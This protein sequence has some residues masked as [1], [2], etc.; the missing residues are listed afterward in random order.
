M[1]IQKIYKSGE[2]NF[3]NKQLRRANLQNADLQNINLQGSD[4]SYADLRGANLRGANL[5]HCYFN[6]ANLTGADLTGA[7]LTGSYFIKAYMG[8]VNCYKAIL[9]D[10]YFTGTFLTRANLC[11]ADL[12]SAFFGGAH[13]AGAI[14]KGALYSQ[15]TRFDKII[16][17][18]KLGM[19]N[20]S[21]TFA[22][23]NQKT[24]IAELI[25]HFEQII[26][27]THH[28]LGG[29]ITVKNFE[30]TRPDI[31]WLD[32]FSINKQGKIS[33]LGSLNNKATFLQLKWMEKWIKSFVN[34]SSSFVRD[35]PRIIEEKQLTF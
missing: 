18:Q 6:E 5:S 26:E 2:R 17:P 19:I 16:N 35:L 10:A 11:R 32:Y 20:R 9:K 13:L 8:K 28:Y 23:T 1:D 22:T 21:S 27:I 7:D 31:D 24:T 12:S 25:T 29:T 4:L 15:D 34:R 33:Y 14:F 3:S 30:Q